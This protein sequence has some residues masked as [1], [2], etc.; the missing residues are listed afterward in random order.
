M[1]TKFSCCWMFTPSN[2]RVSRNI[3]LRKMYSIS[4]EFAWRFW[5]TNIGQ[6]RLKFT[7]SSK[8][9]ESCANKLVWYLYGSLP[10]TRR[11]NTEP[12]IF[13]IEVIFRKVSKIG[14]M[15]SKKKK[16]RK[17]WHLCCKLDE[18]HA[19]FSQNCVLNTFLFKRWGHWNFSSLKTFVAWTKNGISLSN[20]VL[21][22][23]FMDF[24]CFWDQF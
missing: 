2:P 4:N 16:V 8:V 14:T 23:C 13:L 12:M 18:L 21:F 9:F 6:M 1:D 10:V 15:L 22:C 19:S 17:V 24:G 5:M 7:F 3:F 20:N 11:F